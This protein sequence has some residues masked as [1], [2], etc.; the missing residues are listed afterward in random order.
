MLKNT[1]ATI[2]GF[3][4]A[5]TVVYIIETLLGHAFFPLPEHID[6]NDLSSIKANL[7]LIPIGAKLFVILAHFSGIIA[8]MLVAGMISKTS[9]IPAYIV[10]GLLV[11]ATIGTIV[12][13]PKTVWFAASDAVLAI[14]AFY[15]G[16]SLASRYVYGVLV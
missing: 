6:P 4:V 13:L 14:A 10:G 2:V 5:A 1:I 3:I 9:M 12:M 7:H 8:G 15:F 16:K 11:L